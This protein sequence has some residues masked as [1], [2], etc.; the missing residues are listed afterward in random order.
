MSVRLLQ[1][2]PTT[3]QEL[4]LGKFS[5]EAAAFA[6]VAERHKQ[7]DKVIK[8]TRERLTFRVVPA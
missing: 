8:S 4:D 5:D 1:T 7:R 2:D 3:G 6:E